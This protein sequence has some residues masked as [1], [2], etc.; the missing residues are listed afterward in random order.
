MKKPIFKIL[1]AVSLVTALVV[2][3][4]L[5]ACQSE[6][7]PALTMITV[8]NESDTS[9]TI[10]WTTNRAADSE[11]EY[12]TDTTYGDIGTV[13]ALVTEH[14]VT[15]TGLTPD[16]TYYYVV[17]STDAN[18][19]LGASLVRTF[20]T[21]ELVISEVAVVA[22][23][24]STTIT[25]MTDDPA[26]SQ[27][28]YGTT[29]AYGKSTTATTAYATSHSVTVTGLMG[30]T[31]YHY[32][33]K[34]VDPDGIS[35]ASADATFTTMTGGRLTVGVTDDPPYKN[36]F[37]V[38]KSG[39]LNF[40]GRV[41]ETLN[42][43][44]Q[45]GDLYPRLAKSWEYDS[46]TMTATYHLEEDAVWHD[47]EPV[48]ATDVKFSWDTSLEL[49]DIQTAR[50]APFIDEIV[51][52]DEHTVDFVLLED[53]PNF[54][55]YTTGMLI[56]PEHLWGDMTAVEI[57]DYAGF[58]NDSGD[59]PPIG[60]G[61]FMYVEHEEMSYY[62]LERNPDYYGG[63]PH[64]DEVMYKIFLNSEATT[65]AL[66]DGD[67]DCRTWV[68]VS[69]IP[70]LLAQE[71]VA[72]DTYYMFDQYSVY[73]NTR[74][75]P[76]NILEFRQAVSLAVDRE[77]IID[78]AWSGYGE[79]IMVPYVT[80]VDRNPEVVWP[81]ADMTQTEREAAANLI[82]DDIPLMSDKPADPPD[83]WV[84]TYDGT[85]LEF[86]IVISSSVTRTVRAVEIIQ[87]DMAELGIKLTIEIPSLPYS[88]RDPVP[89]NWTWIY[90]GHERTTYVDQ[91][92]NEMAPE[93]YTTNVD[94]PR[95]GWGGREIELAEG[96][97]TRYERKAT[98]ID[99]DAADL[100]DLMWA[101][102]KSTGATFHT[103]MLQIQEDYV[104]QMA[105]PVVLYTTVGITT[106]RTD[107]F[108][109]WDLSNADIDGMGSTN[110]P[111][112]HRNLLSLHLIAND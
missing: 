34:S 80:E 52:V 105:G 50:P 6:P 60:S 17:R 77:K 88:G 81:G 63:T 24:E 107:K 37:N 21:A 44:T 70:F 100:E 58:G 38:Y 108:T 46:D 22:D 29:T 101:T 64:I 67:I 26:T 83:G 54:V 94:G 66:L 61:P 56:A 5:S 12:G 40:W 45:E 27:V 30:S 91:L 36:P 104:A 78:F 25:W 28:E 71:N 3:S 47:G 41:Y 93:V 79:V 10:S 13:A 99:Q 48:T 89:E 51:V 84:R 111:L 18:G 109:G 75:E 53:F 7:P 14:S 43:L 96:S 2:S 33:V 15:L 55:M 110:P 23:S 59:P 19:V 42:Y 97:I 31:A 98:I 106:Y 103:N 57:D 95:V 1:G 72:V 82:L 9:V 92:I 112:T 32:K 39:S 86:E 20:D 87:G 8:T 62:L 102:K 16:T 35:A 65:L 4:L 49:E 85:P 69:E 74:Y 76:M 68:S 11:V 90:Y 73:L